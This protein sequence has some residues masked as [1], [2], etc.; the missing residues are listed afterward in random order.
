MRIVSAV[1]R[2]AALF[3]IILTL[4]ACAAPVPVEVSI[5]TPTP[6]APT[7]SPTL[8]P[9]PTSTPSSTTV[10]EDEEPYSPQELNGA[11]PGRTMCCPCTTLMKKSKPSTTT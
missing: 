5:P 4:S 6:Q 10:A 3:L 11:S 2:I 8:T 1:C 9:A 7:P